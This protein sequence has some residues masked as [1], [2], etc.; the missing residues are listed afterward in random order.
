MA[1]KKRKGRRNDPSSKSGKVRAL[2]ESGMTAAQIAKQVKCT[3][4]LVYNIKS[5]AG[6][7]KPGPGRPRKVKSTG[8]IT[9]LGDILAAVKNSEKDRV[10]MLAA[11]EKIQAVIKE[12]LA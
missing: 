2:L 12:A 4:A 11:L 7:G 1:T 5:K 6:G 10:R 9:G 8:S 3:V